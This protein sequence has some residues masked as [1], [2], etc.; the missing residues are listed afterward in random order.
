V[1]TL[2]DLQ[3][4]Q[5]EGHEGT[6]DSLKSALPAD[7]AL[8]AA[9]TYG[10]R[11]LDVQIDESG[12]EATQVDLTVN[13]PTKP[14]V[15]ML[16]MY[17]PT[18]WNVRWTQGTR[19]AAVLVSGYYR[20]AVAGLPPEVPQLN[21]SYENK[22]TCGYFY[23]SP[24]D[25]S[26]VNP[27]AR[28]VFGRAADMVWPGKAG[29]ADVLVGNPVG[30]GAKLLTSDTT[31]PMSFVDPDA[32]LAGRAGLAQAV[33]KGLLRP[34]TEADV[35]AWMNAQRPVIARTGDLPPVAG[36]EAPP[37]PRRPIAA[38]AYVVLGKFRYP[39]GLFGGN[40]STFFIPQGVPQPE[41]NPGHS[42]VYDF[43]SIRCLG[44][45]CQ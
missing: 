33:A 21:T 6:C 40:G 9:G 14:V 37:L 39:A 4:R 24:N 43:N 15:L 3:R 19:I 1:A 28:K 16:G 27:M 26:M 34:A 10:G 31:S 41:G 20:Q 32:P 30:P 5:R 22:G 8:Y 44:P 25:L 11:R 35:D 42:Y 17:E 13:E 2:V 45:L 29:N 7:Y 38:G 12:H 36:V 23:V 18:I